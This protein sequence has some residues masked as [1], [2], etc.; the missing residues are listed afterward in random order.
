MRL[1][2]EK[3]AVGAAMATLS[4]FPIGL[5]LAVAALL[6]RLREVGASDWGVY[7]FGGFAIAYGVAVVIVGY[8]IHPEVRRVVLNWMRLV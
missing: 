8:V 5:F 2:I 1:F 7:I 6:G 3:I 4:I